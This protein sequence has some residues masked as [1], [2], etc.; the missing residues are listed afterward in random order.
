MKIVHVVEAFAGGT[1]NAVVLLANR[2]TADKHDVTV[3][4]SR[5]PDTPEDVAALFDTRVR[6]TYFAIPQGLNLKEDW[7]ASRSLHNALLQLAPDIVHLHSS[8]AGSVGRMAAL[9]LPLKV[10]YT[11]HGFAFN[12]RDV[13]EWKRKLFW[14]SE[15]ALGKL[16]GHIMACSSDEAEA[17]QSFAATTRIPNAVDVPALQELA[18]QGRSALRQSPNAPRLA[19]VMAGRITAARNPEGFS[20]VARK[21]K[22]VHPDVDFYWL[23]DGEHDVLDP[24]VKVTGWLSKADLQ[25]SLRDADIYFHPS[26]W[27]GLPFAIL[28]AMSQGLPVIASSAGGNKE[29]VAPGK[30]G[31]LID[32]PLSQVEAVLGLLAE[33][34]QRERMGAAGLARVTERFNIE[35]YFR[36]VAALYST[37]LAEKR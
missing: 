25:A 28:E 12:R 7:E 33:H 35:A 1:L 16:P 31:Y 4:H 3:I 19:V 6:L 30:T 10:V 26:R 14:A 9:G 34:G 21:V 23:G 8:K 15:W 13:P 24:V 29:A 36:Q 2:Q 11:P 27:E 18:A 5:R 20:E 37:L 22:A 32:H 17:A